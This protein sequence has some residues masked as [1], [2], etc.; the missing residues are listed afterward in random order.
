MTPRTCLLTTLIIC[1]A[2]AG[3]QASDWTTLTA[4]ADSTLGNVTSL[5]L[6]QK[7]VMEMGGMK[8]PVNTT[9]TALS[10]AYTRT[11]TESMMG[12]FEE[13]SDGATLTNVNSALG[14]YTVSE[15]VPA[16]HDGDELPAFMTAGFA[17]NLDGFLAALRPFDGPTEFHLAGADTFT[18][19]ERD[20][21]FQVWTATLDTTMTQDGNE[22]HVD[23][24]R[25]WICPDD[26]LVYRTRTEITALVH[27]V[28][29]HLTMQTFVTDLEL[30]A[31]LTPD[32]FVFQPDAGLTRAEPG[33]LMVQTTME[34]RPA[35]DVALHDLAGAPVELSS[36]RGQTVILDFWGTTC[37]P[38]RAEL[39]E[40]KAA[41][42]SGDLTATVLIV[43]TE[44]PARVEKYVTAQQLPMT[45]LLD[46]GSAATMAFGV[47]FLPT[48]F[49]IGPD[50]TIT[51][52]YVGKT[53]VEIL[54]AAYATAAGVEDHATVNA[55]I[56]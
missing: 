36:F 41:L 37:P 3:A 56:Q 13:I 27:G 23:E 42:E 25:A 16:V 5:R 50:G 4:R 54:Q 12:N 39:R 51:D 53:S 34:G 46:Q 29:Q 32:D 33:K 10:P 38:C 31:P 8:I 35:P 11:K 28:E 19:G 45:C 22:V 40:M 49:V 24:L 17:V 6:D 7:T 47:Q 1:T 44:D 48:I 15:A 18:V 52:H 21:R 14:K 30:N 43:S 2:L 20:L 26:G 9:T 55:P